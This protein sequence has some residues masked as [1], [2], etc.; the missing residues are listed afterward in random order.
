MAIWIIRWFSICLFELF[1]KYKTEIIKV[2]I[3]VENF[4]TPGTMYSKLRNPVLL[5]FRYSKI[6]ESSLWDGLGQSRNRVPI[7]KTWISKPRVLSVN[8][9]T[10]ITFSVPAPDVFEIVRNRPRL[11]RNGSGNRL[12]IWYWVWK[13]FFLQ[14]QF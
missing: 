14:V 2:N 11:I 3:I 1:L 8:K 4:Q 7:F 10:G 12:R 13:S 5:F 9:F 6:S